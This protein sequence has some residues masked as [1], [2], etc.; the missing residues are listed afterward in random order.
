ME[1]TAEPGEEQAETIQLK[2]PGGLWVEM[3]DT[4]ANRRGLMILLRCLRTAEGRPLVTYDQLAE[5]LGYADRRNVHNFWMEFKACGDLEAFLVCRQ[6]VDAQ[7][8][9]RCEQIWQA[10]PLWKATRVYEE[11][12]QRWPESGSMLSEANIRITSIRNSN[13]WRKS[14]RD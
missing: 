6:K 12:R 8:V 1:D 14:T 2:L 10:H 3:P 5:E 7:V 13:V 4:W 9:S 11:Y